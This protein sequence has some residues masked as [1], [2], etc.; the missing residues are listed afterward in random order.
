[1][2]LFKTENPSI[3]KD[4]L[5]FLIIPV[6]GIGLL[7]LATVIPY[8]G[9]LIQFLV[10]IIAFFLFFYIGL[11]GGEKA[12][13]NKPS[14]K[15]FLFGFTLLVCTL[16]FAIP[17]VVG[18]YTYPLK[19]ARKVKEQKHTIMT[20]SQASE[21][22]TG[23]LNKE[24][25]SDGFFSYALYTEELQL[26]AKSFNAYLNEQFEDVDDLGSLIAAIVN[27]ILHAVP[28]LLK[29]LLCTKLGWVKEAGSVG[30][31]FWYLLSFALMYFGWNTSSN[32]S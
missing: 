17:Y 8:V 4:L 10:P 18:Y 29:G 28:I 19:V 32:N 6:G 25:G 24:I 14:K 27:T 2:T 26:S 21:L 9:A 22:I 1:M 11:F 13:G 23:A 16:T 3:A 15:I 31:M 20:Y 12:N 30:L 7:H 5:L